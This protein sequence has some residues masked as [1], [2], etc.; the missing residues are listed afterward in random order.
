MRAAPADRWGLLLE[1][2]WSKFFSSTCTKTHRERRWWFCLLCGVGRRVFLTHALLFTLSAL[3]YG[4]E[5]VTDKYFKI[6][7]FLLLL[8]PLSGTI[9][10][11]FESWANPTAARAA[12]EAGH[13]R[14]GAWTRTC[15]ALARGQGGT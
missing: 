14:V 1:A 15:T 8:V 2:D 4:S 13:W 3:V 9:G 11:H 6:W 7:P 5:Y 12:A 10:R